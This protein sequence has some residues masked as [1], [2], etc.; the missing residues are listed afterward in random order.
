MAECAGFE[1][2]YARKG[3]GG[4]NPSLSANQSPARCVPELRDDPTAAVGA[5]V[6]RGRGAPGRAWAALVLLEDSSSSGDSSACLW[7]RD[8]RPGF[9]GLRRNAVARSGGGAACA[10]SAEAC[11]KGGHRR[12]IAE[13]DTGG[14]VRRR[15]SDP[16]P[17]VAP[18]PRVRARDP[19]PGF[20]GLRR[21]AVARSGGGAACAPSAEACPEGEHRRR[22]PEAPPVRVRLSS[23]L[24]YVCTSGL[25]CLGLRSFLLHEPEEDPPPHFAPRTS[26]TNFQ[27]SACS[28]EWPAWSCTRVIFV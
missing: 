28:G 13:T 1:N 21:N 12:R 2:R 20:R 14:A 7:T 17:A 4:S 26:S 5:G 18:G 8:P 6:R 10:P 25:S 9:R 11:P 24:R 19:R 27:T 15:P 22:I 3:I 23:D 16:A